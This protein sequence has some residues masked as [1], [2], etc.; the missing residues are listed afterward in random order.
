MSAAA[1]ALGVRVSRGRDGRAGRIVEVNPS[2]RH[3]GRQS[4]DEDGGGVHCLLSI[5]IYC[6]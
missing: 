2:G 6:T 3:D 1:R 4:S 5:L